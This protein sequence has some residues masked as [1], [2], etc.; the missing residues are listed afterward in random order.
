MTSNSDIYNTDLVSIINKYKNEI[1]PFLNNYDKIQEFIDNVMGLYSKTKISQ[2]FYVHF[3]KSYLILLL[4][5]NDYISHKNGSL[6]TNSGNCSF[7]IADTKINGE[8]KRVFNKVVSMASFELQEDDLM[9]F[10]ILSANILEYLLSFEENKCYRFYI[11]KYLGNTLSYCKYVDGIDYWD[12]NDFNFNNSL[13]PYNYDNLQAKKN[14]SPYITDGDEILVCHYEAIEKPLDLITLFIRYY[15]KN[16]EYKET[17]I[18][19]FKCLYELYEFIKKFGLEYG[20]MHNDLHFGNI[21]YDERNKNL[22]LIDFGRSS[23]AKFM[24][25]PVKEIDEMLYTNFKKINLF[26]YYSYITDINVNNIYNQKLKLFSYCHSIKDTK[27]NKYF[28]VICDLI[29]Y[30]LNMYVR[31]LYYLYQTDINQ[32]QKIY[33]EFSDILYINYNNNV[34]NLIFNNSTIELPNNSIDII[35]EKYYDIKNNFIEKLKT[36]IEGLTIKE[37]KE[38]YIMIIEGLLYTVLLLKCKKTTDVLHTHYQL[39]DNNIK[40]FKD[41]IDKDIFTNSKYLEIL[42]NDTYLREFIV[43]NSNIINGGNF[44]IKSNKMVIQ[45][46]TKYL[47]KSV[48]LK[49]TSNAYETIYNQNNNLSKDFLLKKKK[50]LNK[51]KKGGGN[52]RLLKN[53]KK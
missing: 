22:I 3:I 1:T 49:E 44:E 51:R 25:E 8:K 48:S 11:P 9:I 10:D 32:F 19:V 36:P 5:W 18:N 39:L 6:L 20:F 16:N 2:L 27:T 40:D 24:D 45:S 46:K 33:L 28:G 41:Y 15:H 7:T 50:F 23:F 53:Y 17:V 42:S 34:N 13:S 29:A 37:T 30:A 21:I 4:D 14:Y 38:I 43:N 31:V 35:I 52:K 12:Y 47:L 26:E